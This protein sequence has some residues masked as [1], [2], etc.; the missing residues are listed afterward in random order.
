MEGLRLKKINFDMDWIASE[1][2]KY[3][4]QAT[5]TIYLY[6]LFFIFAVSLVGVV[7]AEAADVVGGDVVYGAQHVLTVLHLQPGH[8]VISLDK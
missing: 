5:F 2:L 1:Y 8:I 3:L 7:V 4:L 6:Y